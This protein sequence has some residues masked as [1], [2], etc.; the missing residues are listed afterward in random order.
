MN[1]TTTNFCSNSSSNGVSEGYWELLCF[2][3]VNGHV[4][5][6]FLLPIMLVGLHWNVM[7]VMTV[8]KK[9][10]YH[11]PTI[12]LLLNLVGTGILLL[13]I[14]FP[15][16]IVTGIVSEYIFGSTDVMT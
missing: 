9:R 5:A 10:L 12:M 3:V 2:R 14:H 13:L 7:V 6:A 1:N 11:Q 8:I 16:V 15:N 4:T